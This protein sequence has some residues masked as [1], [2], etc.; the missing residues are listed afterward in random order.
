MTVTI[1]TLIIGIINDIKNISNVIN[2]SMVFQQNKRHL[3]VIQ[4]KNI[5]LLGLQYYFEYGGRDGGGG[6]K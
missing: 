2:V 4:V 3:H 5:Y 6:D 1:I